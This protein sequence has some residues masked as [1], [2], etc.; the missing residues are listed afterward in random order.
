MDLSVFVDFNENS[1][2]NLLIKD[3]K[4]QSIREI[5]QQ[6]SKKLT[7]VRKTKKEEIQERLNF[8]DRIPTFLISLVI[9]IGSFLAYNVGISL[10]MFG[11]N[12]NHFGYGIVANVSDHGIQDVTLPLANFARTVFVATINAP[13]DKPVVVD[14][15][16]VVKRVINFTIT[17]DH[18]FADGSDAVIILKK[19]EEVWQNPEK[20][21]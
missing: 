19:I 9:T 21:L 8:F 20:F 17:F 14:D 16:L 6:M 11:L 5:G 18:R 3:C 7:M 10:P 13:Y 1:M 12:K 15:K 2:V 4:N